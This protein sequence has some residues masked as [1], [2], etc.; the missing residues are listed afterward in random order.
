MTHKPKPKAHRSIIHYITLFAN[1]FSLINNVITLLG[2]ETRLAGKSLATIVVL[3][4]LMM[5]VLT[6]TWFCLLVLLFLYFTSLHLSMMVSI[7]LI[8]LLNIIVLIVLAIAISRQKKNLM[9]AATREQ[10][11]EICNL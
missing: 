1:V 4:L 7:S 11:R 5:S 10:C 9:F 6:I 3:S 8:L 2:I